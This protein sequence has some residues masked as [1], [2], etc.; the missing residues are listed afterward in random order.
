MKRLRFLA[1]LFLPKLL[2]TRSGDVE[3]NPGPKEY[4][5]I[6]DSVLF[7]IAQ[8]ITKEGKIRRLGA[9]LGVSQA[10][11]D[12]YMALSNTE[13]AYQ[14]CV[15]WRDK[16]KG[17]IQ[18]EAMKSAL[19]KAD[20]QD[21]ANIIVP[22]KGHDILSTIGIGVGAVGIGILGGTALFV[23]GGLAASA[24]GVAGG[25]ATLN[26]AA[27]IMGIRSMYVY[28]DRE[29]PLTDEMIDILLQIRIPIAAS[30]HSDTPWASSRRN[31]II[32]ETK[33]NGLDDQG[34]APEVKGSKQVAALCEL[35][36]KADLKPQARRIL[37]TLRQNYIN[38]KELRLLAALNNHVRDEFHVHP[39]L[40]KSL[41]R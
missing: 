9:N 29:V 38:A 21:I 34:L 5:G 8:I 14:M 7:H 26:V 23:T 17:I 20:C 30:R 15:Y 3:L 10:E 28:S 18:Y 12:M 2:L 24:M 22:P 19:L 13:G 32:L 1:A 16:T 11:I 25:T 37:F 6:G 33:C 41:I 39:L 36:V 35:L 4:R 31:R 40:T 27:G